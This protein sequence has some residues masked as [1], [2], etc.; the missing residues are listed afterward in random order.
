MV[1]RLCLV[2]FASAALLSGCVSIRELAGLPAQNDPSVQIRSAE[3]RWLLIKNPRF[4]DV[5]SEPEYIWVEEDKLPTTLKSLLLGKSSLLAP[6]EVV[7][8]YGSPPGG[9]RISPRQKL[10]YQ[11]EEPQR[12]P[13]LGR[14]TAL[15]PAP[16]ARA[17]AGPA[18]PAAAPA[19]PRGFVVFVDTTR[20][21]ID[22]TAGDGVRPG[23]IVSLRRDKI[24]IVHPISGEL[25]GELDEEVATGRVTEVR[26]KFSVVEVQGLS[27]GAEVKIKDRVV[28]R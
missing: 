11:V 9:G 10:P 1:T 17:S 28:V 15:S 16:V 14:E 19:P 20:I 22:L 2:L 24:P 23:T 12:Q 18:A 5:A 6:P 4:G 25:L 3:P 13:V 21:V 26:E 27:P 8:K 7:A